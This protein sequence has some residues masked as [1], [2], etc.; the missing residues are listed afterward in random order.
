MRADK[1]QT[2]G[3][4]AYLESTRDKHRDIAFDAFKAMM[5]GQASISSMARS[6]DVTY[7]TMEK[8]RSVYLEEQLKGER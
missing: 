2:I 4:E 7:R 1:I 3:L 5:E 8:W 6:F